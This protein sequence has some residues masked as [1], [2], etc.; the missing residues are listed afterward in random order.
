MGEDTAN[1]VT[2]ADTVAH[3]DR[4]RFWLAIIISVQ[5]TIV[6]GGICGFL[7]YEALQKISVGTDILAVLIMVVQA[8]IQTL[9]ITWQYYYGSSSGSTAKGVAA[10]KSGVKGTTP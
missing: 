10:E 1:N 3:D 8:E 5:F 4:V 9:T 6:V 7:I 2:K